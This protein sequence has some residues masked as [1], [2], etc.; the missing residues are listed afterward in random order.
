[1]ACTAG[2]IRALQCHG[3][4]ELRAWFLAPLLDRDYDRAQRASQFLTE[5]QGGSDV[6]AN[7]AGA[8]PAGDE[9]WRI[10]PAFPGS[11][12]APQILSRRTYLTPVASAA[13]VAARRG[14]A[15]ISDD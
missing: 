9:R 12:R 5:V 8:V 14:Y 15:F 4:T 6:G 2:L 3:S 10:P 13:C 7:L 1:M 11:R